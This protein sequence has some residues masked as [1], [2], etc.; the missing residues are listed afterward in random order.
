MDLEG[1]RLKKIVRESIENIIA[2]KRVLEEYA[3]VGIMDGVELLVYT[4]DSG[5]IPHLHLRD[6]STK[7]KVFD[8]CVRL[9]TNQY[10]SHGR[11]K[12]RMNAKECREFDEFMRAPSAIPNFSTNYECAV[13]MWNLNNSKT[14]IDLQYNEKGEIIIPN[15]RDLK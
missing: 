4:D 8:C 13:N 9:D 10:F 14:R 5:Y 2:S 1:R 3:R 7:G 11:H 12:D 6:Y 15:Y